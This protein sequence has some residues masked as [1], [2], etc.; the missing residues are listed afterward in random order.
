ML[1]YFIICNLYVFVVVNNYFMFQY[2]AVLRYPITSLK[3]YQLF[4][5]E[6]S[7]SNRTYK[8]Y[9]IFHD[10]CMTVLRDVYSST[11]V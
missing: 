4:S 7:R 11:V 2:R 10:R 8:D 5:L 1:Q 9:K 6:S 3:W